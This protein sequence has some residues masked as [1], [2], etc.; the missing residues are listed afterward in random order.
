MKL[1]IFKDMHHS[2]ISLQFFSVHNN[3]G[4]FTKGFKNIQQ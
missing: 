4:L 2:K 1:S 3:I